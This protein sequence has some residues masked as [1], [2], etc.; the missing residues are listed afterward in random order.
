VLGGGVVTLLVP[1]QPAITAPARINPRNTVQPQRKAR[2]RLRPASAT[3]I[4]ARSPTITIGSQRRLSGWKKEGGT[5]EFAAVETVTVAV[6][7][8]LELNDMRVQSVSRADGATR[9][10]RISAAGKM[11]E[12]I[13]GG[14]SGSESTGIAGC[15]PGSRGDGGWIAEG[16]FSHS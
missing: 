5:I 12:A 7:M 16:R 9:L 6:S 3:I 10:R 2:L 14:E 1:P 13:A 15:R 11:N 8:E 4:D